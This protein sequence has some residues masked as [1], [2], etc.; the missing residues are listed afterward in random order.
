[1]EVIRM[2]M[3]QE[4]RVD[5]QDADAQAE[6]IALQRIDEAGAVARPGQVGQFY[7]EAEYE[8][9][10]AEQTPLWAAEGLV[11]SRGPRISAAGLELSAEVAEELARGQSTLVDDARA[12]YLVTVA[13]LSAF[14]RRPPKA[15]WW[16]YAT[17]AG[18]YIGDG[19][20]LASAALLLGETPLIAAVMAVSVAT[21]TVTAGLSGAEVKDLRGRALRR[22]EA[23]ELTEG[24]HEFA[25]LFAGPDSGWSY[26]KALIYV[27]VS[28]AATLAV[29]I[30]VLRGAVD[31]PIVGVVF[32][33]IAAAVAAA[34]WVDSYMYADEVADL[35]ARARHALAREEAQ[36]ASRAASQDWRSRARACAEAES[37]SA[38]YDQRGAAASEHMQALLPRILR[39]N[40][41][42]AGHGHAV[43]P[44]AIGQT[45]RRGGTK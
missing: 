10:D 13:T 45:T 40:P 12:R 22:R 3:H 35:I 14:V 5:A 31:D 18:L 19:V 43:G 16:H 34:S 42:L 15:T 17:K 4:L 26:V 24:Q 7:V 11:A 38:E 8:H 37:L 41:G 23:S 1:L 33:A 20:G 9:L 2:G 21:A 6:S 25:H 28:I 32:G 27:C 36:L 44:T 29:T 39:N 30:A